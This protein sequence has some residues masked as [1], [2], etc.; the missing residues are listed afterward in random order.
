MIRNYFLVAIRNLTRN[1]FFSALN[2][3]GLAVSM[4]ICMAIIMLVADQMTYDRHNPNYDR[5]YRVNTYMVDNNGLPRGSNENATSP[6][7]LRDEL[8]EKYTGVEKAVRIKRGFGNNW[9]ELENQNVNIPIK[10]YFADPEALEFFGH[11]LEH[12]DAATALTAPYSVVLTRKAADKLFKEKNPV[13]MTLTVGDI[14]TYTVTGVLKESQNKSHLVFEA[15]ASMSTIQSLQAQGRF[16]NDLENWMDFWGSWTYILLEKGLTPHEINP[17]FERIYREHIA[18]V[19]NPDAYKAKFKVQALIDITPGPM[20]N[21]P[22]GPSLPW[23]FVYFLSGLAGVIMLTSCFN[24][25]N[26]SIARSLKRAKEI[27]VRKVTGAQRW[28]IFTQFL[29]E[30]V[31]VSFCALML[32][33]ALLVVLKPII[34]ELT[35]AQLF[36]WDLEANYVVFA[37]FIVFAV[38]VGIIAGF[39]P[40]VVLSG[41]QP[42]KVLKNFYPVKI[43]SNMGLRKALLVSQFTVSLVFILTVIVMYKQLDLFLHSDYGFNMKDNIMVRLNN[44]AHQELK[45]ELLKY[46]NIKNVTAS[47]H[48]PAAGETHGNGFKK[49][50]DEKEWTNINTFAVDEDYLRNMEVDLLAGK[51]FSAENGKSNGGFVVINQQALKVLNYTSATDALGE[52]IIYQSDSSRKQIIGVVRDYNHSQL[53]TEIAPLALMYDAEQVRLLQVRYAGDR[54]GAIASIEKAWD[55]VNPGLKADYKDVEAEIKFF[56]NTIF[57]D[58]VHILGVIASLAIMISCL[59]LLGMAMYNIETRMKE[60]CI[61]KV[62]GSSDQQLIVLLSK[63]FLKL[64]IFSVVIG[65]PLAYFLNNLWLQYIAYHTDV[66]FGVIAMGALILIVLGGVTVGSQTLRAAVSNPVDNLKNE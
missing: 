60:I 9:L 4:T 31:V 56:Y 50:L 5:I 36:M 10:G 53:F 59:G 28:Q 45:T 44:T 41:F 11:S 66:S 27:G 22:I 48:I 63:G 33:L 57:G 47:S 32:A 54:E 49:E 39:F 19:P 17:Y 21:N 23:A 30:S 25:T 12:G 58:V 14:G 18:S 61:R 38:F 24:F 34:M 65:T 8:V 52:E 55:R 20:V 62:L 51:F 3:F 26:L 40:A 64:L 15:L 16:G 6:M 35:F 29:T 2:I 13:G 43:F 7:P 42:I 37:V 1:K 46:P